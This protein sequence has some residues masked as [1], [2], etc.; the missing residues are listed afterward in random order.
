MISEKRL[1]NLMGYFML[2]GIYLAIF[3]VALGGTIFLWQ[4][5]DATLQQILMPG[6][7]Y[8]IDVLKIWNIQHL[9]SPIGLIEMGMLILVGIQV[10]RVALLLI[11]YIAK[12][13]YWFILFSGFV[14]SVILYSLIWQA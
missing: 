10:A 8:N 12:R 1:K 13:D 5:H 3:L 7:N 11:Y 6:I 2:A 9:L 4:H 14:L